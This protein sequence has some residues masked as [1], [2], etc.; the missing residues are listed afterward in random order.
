MAAGG[1][2]GNNNPVGVAAARR[3]MVGQ[4]VDPRM[5]FS[6]D[7]IERRLGSERVADHGDVDAEHHGTA[8]KQRKGLLGPHLPVAA[9]DKNQRR[10]PLGSLEEVDAIAFARAVSEIEMLGMP[11]AHFG[12]TTVPAGDDVAAS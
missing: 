2:S 11:R 4:K 6:D 1:P 12:G 10:R 8:G 7:L 5:D 3:Q 9:M